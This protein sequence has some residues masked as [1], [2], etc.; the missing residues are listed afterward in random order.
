[1]AGYISV[2]LS[3]GVVQ[4]AASL[5]YQYIEPAQLFDLHP[6]L[7]TPRGGTLLTLVGIGLGMPGV[8]DAV[9]SLHC[10]FNGS[11]MVKASYVDGARAV[12]CD[13]PK[14]TPGIVAVAVSSLLLH[15][16]IFTRG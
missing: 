10:C 12:V 3:I 11:V 8:S 9:S 2:E 5:T 13:T 6:V 14:A 1:M 16:C 4:T 7:S 15:A